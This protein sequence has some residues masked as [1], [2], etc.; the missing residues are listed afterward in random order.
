[1]TGTQFS[2]KPRLKREKRSCYESYDSINNFY[3]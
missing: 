1:M 3:Y 2:T